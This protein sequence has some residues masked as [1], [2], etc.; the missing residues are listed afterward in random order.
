M[1]LTVKRA[2]S[3]LFTTRA[4][5]LGLLLLW[6]GTHH[7]VPHFEQLVFQTH[8]HTTSQ[9]E[10]AWTEAHP[11]IHHCDFCSAAG[12]I[13]VQLENHL[14]RATNLKAG[15]FALA[16]LAIP[17]VPQTRLARAPPARQVHL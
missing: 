17:R 5:L 3:L 9:T 14:P 12:F 2:K 11:S 4:H 10:L 1:L 6:F 7:T 15:V 13:G 8:A 16:M